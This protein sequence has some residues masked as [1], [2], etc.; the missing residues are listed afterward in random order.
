MTPLEQIRHDVRV[1][2]DAIASAHADWPCRKGCDDCCRSLASA[3]RVSEAE[4]RPI[5]AAIDALPGDTA[6]EVRK[7]IRNSAGA[8]RPVVCPLLDAASGSCRVYDARP[9]AC[10]SYGFYAERD[11]V[12]GC[13]RIEAIARDSSDIV[14]GNHATLEQ[15]MQTLGPV[16]ELAEWVTS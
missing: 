11:L 3:P 6:D 7:H 1:R 13:S 2:M 15:R 5:A 12:L 9:I 10:R 8:S 4:W 16:A 14:W